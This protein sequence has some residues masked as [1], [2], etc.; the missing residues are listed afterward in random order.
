VF[1]AQLEPTAAEPEAAVAKS[2]SEPEAFVAKSPSEP[3]AFVAKSPSEP[4]AFVAKTT[5]EPEA[6]VA[7]STSEPEAPAEAAPAEAAS[8][9]ADHVNVGPTSAV[10]PTSAEN[11]RRTQRRAGCGDRRGGQ[12]NRYLAHH[13]AAPFVGRCTPAF[14]NQTPAAPIELQRAAV[15]PGV[16]ASESE[17]QRSR[18]TIP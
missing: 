14:P 10:T 12:T 18:M 9:K 4:K 11:G 6:A 13:D 15:S 7:K 2:T 17:A 1:V 16:P 3:K 8:A 5:S